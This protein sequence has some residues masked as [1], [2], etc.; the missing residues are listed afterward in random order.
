MND[1]HDELLR[2]AFE[3]VNTY[4][5]ND[6]IERAFKSIARAPLAVL[7]SSFLEATPKIDIAPLLLS[8][9]EVNQGRLEDLDSPVFLSYL[10]ARLQTNE[11]ELR[12]I[13]SMLGTFRQMHMAKEAA[14]DTTLLIA[15]R[16]DDPNGSRHVTLSDLLEQQKKREK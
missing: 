8:I 12:R 4:Q 10:V 13:R 14:P 3:Y 11:A 2:L 6:E 9:E 5:P 16:D 7:I 1:D 15:A